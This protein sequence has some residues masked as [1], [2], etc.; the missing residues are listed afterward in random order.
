MHL[1]EE[2]VY[3]HFLPLHISAK[4]QYKINNQLQKQ[5]SVSAEETVI[6]NS[7]NM[8]T[9]IIYT[10]INT[11]HWDKMQ[12]KNKPSNKGHMIFGTIKNNLV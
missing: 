2:L 3:S 7:E 12:N 5:L 1:T 11:N 4:E 6:Q 8:K 10:Q 9:L